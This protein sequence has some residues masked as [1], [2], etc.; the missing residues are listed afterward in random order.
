MAKP[1]H[2]K[3]VSSR[4]E[5]GAK[6]IA[7]EERAIQRKID[8]SDKKQPAHKEAGGAMQAGARI[9]PV[10]PL[11]EQHLQKPGIEG[12]LEL[13]PMYDAPY[14]KG[15]DKLLDKVALIT[16][17]D[18]G[19][20]RSVAVLFA[21]EGADIALTYLDEHEDAEETKQAVE[22][23]GRRCI[24]L[25]GDVA[26][27]EFCKEAVERT[28]DEFG[29]LDI[30]QRRVPGARQRLPR[31]ERRAFRPHDQ[32]QSLRLFLYVARGGAAHAERQ[33]HCHDRFRHG[34]TRQ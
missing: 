4:F 25:P 12:D 28:V 8:R 29:K 19:I 22:D 31:I 34:A 27:P 1:A 15:S 10:P 6:R 3:R 14:Y 11:P 5:A 13:K 7:E 23:E 32:D 16:G 17:G 18:S 26:D 33:R 2:A 21:R 24:L 9:Y 20:G 30:Q